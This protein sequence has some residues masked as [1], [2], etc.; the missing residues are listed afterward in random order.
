VS[1][2]KNIIHVDFGSGGVKRPLRQMINEPPQDSVQTPAYDKEPISDLYTL[3]EAAKLFAIVPGRLRY[4]ERSGFIVRSGRQGRKRYYTFLDLIGIR[5]A[6][7]LLEKG[8]ALRRVR[9]CVEALRTSLPK[10][11]RPLNSLRVLADGQNLVV[12][13]DR[14]TFEP[15]TG[16]MVINFD[17]GSLTDDVVRVL[18]RDNLTKPNRTAYD[19]YLEGCRFDQDERTFDNA[20]KAYRRA[21]ELD[22]SLGNAFTNLGN[23]LFRR[24]KRDTAEIMFRRALQVDSEQPEAFYNLGFLMYDRGD[25]N[26]ALENFSR[27]VQSSPSFA[28]AHFNLAMVLEELDRP[29]EARS[30]WETYLKLDPTG[31][32]A[33]IARTHLK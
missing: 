11:A 24:D 22:P 16:Q 19:Y 3:E 8:V 29:Q 12:K 1:E 31:S 13:D 14:G 21:I 2:E 30:H 6:K 32:W 17:V 25:I 5:T 23:L 7:G 15:A 18:G 27:A 28:D 20:E 33:E 9:R 10:I 26:E 4:W